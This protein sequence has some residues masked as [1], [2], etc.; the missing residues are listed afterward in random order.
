MSEQLKAHYLLGVGDVV[1]E[2]AEGL[3]LI[4]VVDDSDGG[5]ADNLLG[6]AFGVDG[7]ETGPLTEGLG[8]R[9]IHDG[10][11]LLLAKGLDE[12]LV[13][14]LIAGLVEE[15]DLGAGSLDGLGDLVEATD[16][17]IDVHGVLQDLADGLED[18]GDLFLGDFDVDVLFDVKYFLL[19]NVRHD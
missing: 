15:N 8:V 5:S 11:L 4:T 19:V 17:T 18:I 13:G 9:A 7:A 3:G 12:L 1:G 6:V 10:D 14:T 2:V 16:D